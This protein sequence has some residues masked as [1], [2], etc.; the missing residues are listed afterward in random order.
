MKFL[1][2][3]NSV[4]DHVHIGEKELI[5]PGGIFYAVL[6]LSAFLSPDDELFLITSME[7]KCENLF[8]SLYDKINTKYVRYVMSMPKVHLRID[9]TSQSCE[10]H[11]NI[12]QNLDVKNISNLNEF[13][14]ILINMITGYDITL[15]DIL[16]IRKDYD[17][18]IYLDIHTLSRG[19]EKDHNRPFR[20][21][22]EAA[23][24]IS[25]ADIVQV[26]EKEIYSLSEKKNEFDAAKEI[27]E[28]GLKYLILT[29]GEFG[30]SILYLEKNELKSVFVASL[31]KN[32]SNKIGCGDIF[33]S[34]FFYFYIR[35][36]EILKALKAANTSAG[37]S[38]RYT[39]ID[40]FK[41]LKDDTFSE[42]NKK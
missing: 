22:P 15:Q 19:L 13:D 2:I 41:R 39:N 30:A 42:L 20:L 18:L 36:G 21:I 6:G 27:L 38:T 34:T 25:A 24:W 23:E 9:Q 37:C 8:S 1:L 32:S 10:N 35:Y 5:S 16:N 14:G 31:K 17:G 7:K 4:E 40:D 26:N 28:A 33:G 11:E 29:K 3:G 12:T